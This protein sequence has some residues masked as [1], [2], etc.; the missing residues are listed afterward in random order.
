MLA[1]SQLSQ[2]WVPELGRVRHAW[3]SRQTHERYRLGPCQAATALVRPEAGPRQKAVRSDPGLLGI[4]DAVFQ[5]KDMGSFVRVI[6]NVGLYLPKVF[7]LRRG[8]RCPEVN[9]PNSLQ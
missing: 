3:P 9:C 8:Q 2:E 4:R 5:V 6:P 7:A 1:G